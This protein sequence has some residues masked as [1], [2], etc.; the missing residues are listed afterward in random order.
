MS[1]VQDCDPRGQRSGVTHRWDRDIEAGWRLGSRALPHPALP[2]GAAL[3]MP[4]ILSKFSIEKTHPQSEGRK[5]L[6]L[7][8]P[9][10]CPMRLE[11]EA[12]VLGRSWCGDGV[13]N[14]HVF[15]GRGMYESLSPGQGVC[16]ARRPALPVFLNESA[17]LLCEFQG[18]S[19]CCWTVAQGVFLVSQVGG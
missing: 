8:A 4:H 1:V 9:A 19:V 10:S 11:T 13:D 3:N 15:N 17:F 14:T 16:S 2:C 5:H 7:G 18:D 12:G 6:N